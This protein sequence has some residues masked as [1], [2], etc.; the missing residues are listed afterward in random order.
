VLAG[1][2]RIVSKRTDKLGRCRR[3]P[4][5][6]WR[7]RTSRTS[8]APRTKRRGS[9]RRRPRRN[10]AYLLPLLW[11]KTARRRALARQRWA[12]AASPLSQGCRRRAGADSG[13]HDAGRALARRSDLR[14]GALRTVEPT[15]I[16]PTLGSS[17]GH[18]PSTGNSTKAI[19]TSS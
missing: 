1:A 4:S 8:G 11:R 10:G 9:L 16:G 13:V 18:L 12:I 6:R 19:P 5:T 2:G 7:T 17:D 3:P 15:T 14:F